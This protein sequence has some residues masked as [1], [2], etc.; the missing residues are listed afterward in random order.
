M[1]RPILL[2][3]VASLMPGVVAANE[4]PADKIITG[5]S[6][7]S[8]AGIDVHRDKMPDVRQRMG[9]PSK[10]KWV[11]DEGSSW[12]KYKWVRGENALGVSGA[13]DDIHIVQI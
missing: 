4:C 11:L 3:F 12:A 1:M 6:E 10:A 5:A 7:T 8:L 9:K 2:A 13:K